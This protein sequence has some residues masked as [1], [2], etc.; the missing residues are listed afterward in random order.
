MSVPKRLRRPLAFLLAFTLVFGVVGWNAL[1]DAEETEPSEVAAV[2]LDEEVSIENL[3]EEIVTEEVDLEE[4]ATAE[5][6]AEEADVPEETEE[7]TEGL[8]DPETTEEAKTSETSKPNNDGAEEDEGPAPLRTRGAPKEVPATITS[9]VIQDLNGSTVNEMFITNWFYLA[10]DWD[11]SS[12]GADLHEGDYFDITLPDRMK[13]PSN[14]SAVDFNL[15]D[16]DGV[17]VIARAHVS[18]GPGDRGGSVR[19]TFTDWVEGKENVKGK[20]RLS[21]QFVQSQVDV[22]QPNTFQIQ[23]GSQVVP[24]TVNITGPTDLQPEILGKWG[25]GVEEGG[26]AGAERG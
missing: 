3:D 15:Y 13:F 10:M 21:A 6:P 25:Q 16:E 24:V 17:T 9:F 1:A 8:E 20:I 2:L 19:V 4:A 22:G 11:A 23:V 5:E 12:S 26:C 7:S 14:S 18:P